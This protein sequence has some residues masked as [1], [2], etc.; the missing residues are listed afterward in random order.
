[1]IQSHER[2]ITLAL[3]KLELTTGYVKADD[4]YYAEI[5]ELGIRCVDFTEDSAIDLVESEGRIILGR[6]LSRA[7]DIL[8]RGL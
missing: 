1:M 3:Y 6:E 8:L 7:R 4:T 5:P 2:M